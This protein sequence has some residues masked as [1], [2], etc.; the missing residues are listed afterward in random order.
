MKTILPGIDV[1]IGILGAGQLG[2]MD[3]M[4]ATRLGYKTLIYSD[5]YGCACDVSRHIIGPYNNEKLLREF[6]LQVSVVTW[7]FENIPSETIRKI[8]EFSHDNIRVFPGVE[9]LETSCHRGKEKTLAKSLGI[10]T[11][12]YW[13]VE[14]EGDTDQQISFPCIL[15]TCSGGYDGKGQTRVNDA[16]SLYKAWC[17][18]N[19]VPCIAEEVVNFEREASCILARREDGVMACYPSFRNEHRSGILHSTGWPNIIGERTEEKIKTY[20]RKIA[21]KLKIIGLLAVEYFITASGEV[22]FNE[23][24]PRPHNSGHITLDAARTT[25]F[26]QHIRAICGLPLGSPEIRSS[27]TMINILGEVPNLTPFLS[28]PRARLHLYGK[29]QARPGRK[30][31]HVNYLD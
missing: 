18:L 27:G 28:D 31:G 30:M 12:R 22:V 3:A 23:V 14:Y 7:E 24:A 4:A 11:P 19:K 16:T 2:K 26:E 21:E 20:T 9:A 25:Q 1:T 8:E 13:R 15:K 6:L 10:P 29:G 17:E 5:V